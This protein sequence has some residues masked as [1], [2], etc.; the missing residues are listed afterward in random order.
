V[1]CPGYPYLTPLSPFSDSRVQQ[2][3]SLPCG[4]YSSASYSSSST[5]MADSH[6]GHALLSA[7]RGSTAG[8]HSPWL[9]LHRHNG[10]TVHAAHGAPQHICFRAHPTDPSLAHS[11]RILELL[12]TRGARSSC[13]PCELAE[14]AGRRGREAPWPSAVMEE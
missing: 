7:A 13:S 14:V 4:P 9:E 2:L 12:P 11:P 5:W 8:C 3:M 6:T 10:A 1:K